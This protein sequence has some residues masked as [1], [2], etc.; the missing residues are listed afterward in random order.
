MK[1]NHTRQIKD[2]VLFP[3]DELE[4]MR[5]VYEM[6]LHSKEHYG[7]RTAYRQFE[8]GGR[9]SSVTF[10]EFADRVDALRAFFADRNMLGRH[11]AII[12]ETSVEWIS[13]YLAVISG[14][15]VCVPIDKELSD[16]SIIH[17]LNFADVDCVFV[18]GKCLAKLKKLLPACGNIQTVVVMRGSDDSLAADGQY[19]VSN[20]EALLKQGR[21]A[22]QVKGASVLPDGFDTDAP[23]LIIFTSGTTGANKGVVL[24]NKNITGTLRGCG[25]LLRYPKT[26]FSVLPI[27]HS[28]ELHANLMSS[29]YCGTCV[30]I[31]D[32]LRYFL[33]NIKYFQP[34]MSCM[35][36]VMLDT[37]V[38]QLKKEIE[39]SGKQKAFDKL[40]SV[41]DALRK[42]GIDCRRIFFRKILESLG[43]NLKMII[44]GGAFLDQDIIDFLTAIGIEVYNGYGITECAPVAAVNSSRLVKRGS[45]G[46]VLPTAEVRIMNRD[47][48]GNGEIQIHGD[49]VMLGY[50]KAEEDTSRVFSEDGWLL[51]GDIG[52]VDDDQFLYISGRIKNLII[53]PNGKN[54]YPEEIEEALTRKI[55]AIKECVVLENSSGSGLYGHIYP[56]MD[57]CAA[58]GLATN[59]EIR[60]FLKKD[61]DAFNR[62]EPS[63]KRLSDFEIRDTEFEKN[64]TH[65]ILR[66]KVPSTAK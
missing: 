1:N 58:Q 42:V 14:V 7:S 30:C 23:C 6:L 33:K 32:E 48:N 10:T 34:E 60:K 4:N 44:C 47:E 27:N 31:N 64:T 40:L 35:V 29:M 43:G 59:E 52:Y 21:E 51:T 54:I 55:P 57:Y 53:L 39:R 13:V 16:E 20:Y 66:F 11:F 62:G 36:P 2:H 61:I 24:S 9:E 17:Q 50:Y 15:G 5:S 41:S 65:K 37:I 8:A 45:V 22:L 38:R 28:Y 12:G 19:E 63:Y 56:D 46:R 49:P 18:S 25:R 3:V 26:C